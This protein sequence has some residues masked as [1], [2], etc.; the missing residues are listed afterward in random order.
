MLVKEAPGIHSFIQVTACMCFYV[1]LSLHF[2][3]TD[4][5]KDDQCICDKAATF[6][7]ACYFHQ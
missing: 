2:V 7:R 3:R 6:S 5:N 1:W 4:K